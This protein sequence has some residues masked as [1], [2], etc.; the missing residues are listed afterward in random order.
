M[1][2][3]SSALADPAPRRTSS[4]ATAPE[5]AHH[6]RLGPTHQL[7]PATY[8]G[9]HHDAASDGNCYF[10]FGDLHCDRIAKAPHK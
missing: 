3:A 6:H 8:P 5:A 9:Y 2:T 7:T 4:D 10:V 1:L